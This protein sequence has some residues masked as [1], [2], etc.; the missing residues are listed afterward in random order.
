[1][2]LRFSDPPVTRQQCEDFIRRHG[3]SETDPVLLN[4]WSEFIASHSG[5]D[6]S[7][8]D[9]AEEIRVGEPKVKKP[10][11]SRFAAEVPPPCVLRVQQRANCLL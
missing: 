2:H 11:V 6:D 7:E 1:M 9:C 8:E 10:E 5:S 4:S 3:V